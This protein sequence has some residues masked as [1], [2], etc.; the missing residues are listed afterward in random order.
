MMEVHTINFQL[1]DFEITWKGSMYSLMTRLGVKIVLVMS[2]VS[3]RLEALLV[4]VRLKTLVVKDH[5]LV[6][7]LPGSY[8]IV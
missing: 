7:P 8:T 4:L 3:V 5:S 6:I 1:L 2:Y